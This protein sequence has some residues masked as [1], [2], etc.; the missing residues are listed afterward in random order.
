M[1]KLLSFAIIICCI[2]T[3]PSYV[4]EIATILTNAGLSARTSTTNSAAQPFQVYQYVHPEKDGNTEILVSKGQQNI[5]CDNLWTF[6]AG[7]IFYILIRG[8]AGEI[9]WCVRL[10]SVPSATTGVNNLDYMPVIDVNWTQVYTKNYIKKDVLTST[11]G[12]NGG[13]GTD[14]NAIKYLGNWSPNSGYIYDDS[15]L[16]W[17]VHDSWITSNTYTGTLGITW[18]WTKYT[19]SSAN[20]T[21]PELRLLSK[22]KTQITH[23]Q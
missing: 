3:L 9:G 12:I 13:V 1:K 6:K 11:T 15:Y 21:P 20:M 23:L 2:Q 10:T 8:S 22:R 17:G 19:G 5:V 4:V 18:D 14:T 16:V 7:D